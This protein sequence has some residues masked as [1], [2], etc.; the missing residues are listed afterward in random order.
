MNL[1]EKIKERINDSV[2]YVLSSEGAPESEDSLQNEIENKVRELIKLN[3][4]QIDIE[5]KWIVQ[6]VVFL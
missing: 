3:E 5:R 4:I 2:D 1:N 6:F